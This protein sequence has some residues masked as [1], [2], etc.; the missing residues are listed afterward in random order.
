ME[1]RSASRPAGAKATINFI[2]RLC[3][4]L[5][6]FGAA[7]SKLLAPTQFAQRLG[8]FGIV[9]DAM[10]VPSAWAIL[11]AEMVIG[12][13]LTQRFRG[14]VAAASGMLL[15][16]LA[17]L[18]YGVALG[19]DIDCGC[20]GPAVHIS[21]ETQMLVDLGLLL[22]CAIIYATDSPLADAPG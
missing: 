7:A 17:A 1:I 11:I 13:A 19:L 18:A 6:F 21:L 22:I 10:V 15:L 12:V 14:S 5:V 9:H 4:G 8:E 16:F 3:V 2:A 20:F